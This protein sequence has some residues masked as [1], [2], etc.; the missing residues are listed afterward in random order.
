MRDE[1]LREMLENKQ[2]ALLF[3]MFEWYNEKY[4]VE[5]KVDMQHLKELLD[6][7]FAIDFE[8][9]KNICSIE[10]AIISGES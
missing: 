5:L 6:F 7:D 3:K 9:Q 4:G 2:I 10:D 1:E 8:C